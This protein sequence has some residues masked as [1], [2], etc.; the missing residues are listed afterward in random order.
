MRKAT[1]VTVLPGCFGHFWPST[2]GVLYTLWQILN[3]PTLLIAIKEN[4]QYITDTIHV[5]CKPLC[6]PETSVNKLP[7]Y[8]A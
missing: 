1:V 5:E 2:V 7:I 8:A 4:P 6:C 3:T